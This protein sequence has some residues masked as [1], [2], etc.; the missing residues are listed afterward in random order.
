MVLILEDDN[1]LTNMRAIV[2]A[3]LNGLP[4][5]VNRDMI[6]QAATDFCTNMN[7]KQNRRK[8]VKT[9]FTVHRTR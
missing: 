8:L 1:E 2:E 7:T 3:F 4:N 9:M 5:C 6:D